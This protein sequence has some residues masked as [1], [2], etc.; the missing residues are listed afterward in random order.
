MKPNPYHKTPKERTKPCPHCQKPVVYVVDDDGHRVAVLTRS[1]STGEYD[2]EQHH[3]LHGHGTVYEKA[4]RKNGPKGDYVC[5]TCAYKGPV[6][7]IGTVGYVCHI[8]GGRL[9]KVE[10]SEPAQSGS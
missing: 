6:K 10:T 8:C 2:L 3:E 4:R 1:V 5:R 7:N 9:V